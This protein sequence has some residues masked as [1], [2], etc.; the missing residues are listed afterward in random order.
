MGGLPCPDIAAAAVHAVYIAAA[1]VYIAAA[2]VHAVYIAA[3]Q[4]IAAPVI[5]M[6]QTERFYAIPYFCSGEWRRCQI[7]QW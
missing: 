7:Q 3:P 6:A 1:A 5:N 2:A 4:Y